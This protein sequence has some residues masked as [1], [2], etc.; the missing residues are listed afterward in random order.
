MDSTVGMYIDIEGSRVLLRSFYVRALKQIT[1]LV[2]DIYDLGVKVYNRLDNRISAYQFGDGVFVQ[3]DRGL[4]DIGDALI[5]SIVVLQHR[6]LKGGLASAGIAR[7][8]FA[9]V[10]GCY[11][12]DLREAYKGS[13]ISIGS[14]LLTLTQV[15][16]TALGNAVG[17]SV[18]SGPRLVFEESLEADFVRFQDFF[19]QRGTFE[20]EIEGAVDFNWLICLEEEIQ[21]VH[22]VA[23]GS[24]PSA[25]ELRNHY[26]SYLGEFNLG[27]K[28]GFKELANLVR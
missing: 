12:R 15:M 3:P 7:G 4:Q 22:R 11:R 2:E 6:L 1:G 26:E 18:P 16:G 10:L 21:E 14:G 9:D 13:A 17:L 8:E 24:V 20:Q 28:P 23:F 27:E 5:I 19:V 25:Q